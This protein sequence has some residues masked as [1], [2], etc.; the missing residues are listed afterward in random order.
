[1]N[2]QLTSATTHPAKTAN[3]YRQVADLLASAIAVILVNSV[4]SKLTHVKWITR[5]SVTMEVHA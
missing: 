1:M 4:T 5:P 2:S 3:V